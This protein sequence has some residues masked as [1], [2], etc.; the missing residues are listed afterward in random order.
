MEKGHKRIDS[1]LC[2]VLIEDDGIVKLSEA[3]WNRGRRE[4]QLNRSASANDTHH[5][6][7]HLTPERRDM[8]ALR[9]LLMKLGMR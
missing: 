2:A 1:R 5:C 6:R 7:T 8:A 3:R 4:A 9:R